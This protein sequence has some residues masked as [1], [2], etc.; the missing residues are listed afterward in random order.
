MRCEADSETSRRLLGTDPS[1]VSRVSK[2]E[3]SQVAAAGQLKRSRH[4][5][6]I[7]RALG[8]GARR[9]GLEV[10]NALFFLLL[11]LTGLPV[12]MDSHVVEH[13]KVTSGRSGFEARLSVVVT[14]TVHACVKLISVLD[15]LQ[16]LLAKLVELAFRTDL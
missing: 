13:K 15:F 10:W 12:G 8:A 3:A 9:G 6:G 14:R 11:N 16:D 7:G 1:G 4:A 5:F 2:R